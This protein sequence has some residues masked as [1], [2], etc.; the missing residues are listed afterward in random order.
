MVALGAC[1]A[2]SIASKPGHRKQSD[3]QAERSLI[4]T[5]QYLSQLLPRLSWSY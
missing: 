1:S 3:M 2:L 5:A 4:Y